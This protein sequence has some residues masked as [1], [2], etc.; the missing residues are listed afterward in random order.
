MLLKNKNQ[1]PVFFSSTQ[2]S[3]LLRILLSVEPSTYLLL[4]EGKNP[5]LRKHVPP[6]F[7][8]IGKCTESYRELR[9]E[10]WQWLRMG[11]SGLWGCSH[12]PKGALTQPW[13]SVMAKLLKTLTRS[14]QSPTAHFLS[15]CS[16]FLLPQVCQWLWLGHIGN[17][18]TETV[19]LETKMQPLFF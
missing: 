8:F 7:I 16:R 5:F 10:Y 15:S 19:S 11:K 12:T 2:G 9:I 4:K 1:K 17:Q 6:A 3:Y 13:F 14:S 18:I